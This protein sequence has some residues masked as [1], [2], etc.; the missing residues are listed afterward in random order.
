MKIH[1]KKILILSLLIFPFFHSCNENSVEPEFSYYNWPT[2]TPEE[3]GMNS[4][5]L[6]QAF[7]QGENAGFVDGILV[8]KNGY[9]V[10]EKYYNGYNKGTPHNVKSV[11]KSFLSAMTGIALRDEIIDSLSEKVLDYFPEYIYPAIDSTKFDITVRHLLMMRMG[12]DTDHNL[13][14]YLYNSSNWVKA[15]IELPLIYEPGTTF[16]YNTFQTHLLSALLTKASGLNTLSFAKEKLLSEMNIDCAEWQKDPQGYYFGGNNMYFTPRDMARL[17]YLYLNNG[18]LNGKQIVPELWVEESTTN[19]TN[20]TNSSWGD[21]DEVNYG[22]LWWLGKIKAHE[23]FLAIG[24][25]GQFVIVFRDLNM[26]VVATSEWYVEWET[27][28]QQE[29]DVLSIVANYIVPAVN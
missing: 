21:L 28:D 24:H 5:L 2:S 15:T 20:F 1:I 13:Y 3:Q 22:Y 17:G 6:L 10:A 19:Y 16:A 18:V 26:I 27:A 7:Q 4:G 14:D 8:I 23:V 29:R 25:G 11:S 9:L 12:I